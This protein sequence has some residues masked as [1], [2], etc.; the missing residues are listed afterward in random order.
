MPEAIR[1]S[2]HPSRRALLGAAAAGVALAGAWLSRPAGAHPEEESAPPAP[3]R[4]DRRLKLLVL[5]GTR[6]LGPAIV[7]H[8]LARG[9]EVT[10]FNRGKSNPQLYPGLEKLRGDRG[11]PPTPRSPAGTPADL[12]ALEGRSFDAVIDTSGYWPEQM[13]SVVGLLKDHVK[14][15]VF[16]S[17]ISVYPGFGT[18]NT[19]ITEA[20]PTG[21]KAR[22]AYEQWEYGPF[23]ALAE[24][25][26]E[27]L[28]PGR[29]TNIRPGLIVGPGDASDRFTWWPVRVHRGGEVLAPGN[30]EGHCQFIDVRDLGAWSVTCAEQGTV[31]VYNATGFPG[32][33]SFGEF[34]AGCKCAIRTDCSFTWASE[35]FLEKHKVAPFQDMP[36]WIPDAALPWVNVEAAIAQGLTFR[37]IS[38]TIQDTL[39]WALAE[40]KGG[41]LNPR[42]GLAAEREQNLLAAW[43]TLTAQGAAT[44][45][46]GNEGA[47]APREE[48]AAD[49]PAGAGK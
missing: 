3:D 24:A 23:K 48:S 7:D 1:E 44:K 31:G 46:G 49:E 14:Q 8:A 16:I 29:V 19:E 26:A 21:V 35:A 43:R 25:A 39:A 40:P 27:K 20:T 47:P 6:F 45:P 15:Y 33:L 28:M 12:K 5:G 18:S 22:S 2:A 4:A 32:H 41:K 11:S 38:D 9:H 13:E 17:T 34:L 10:L 37:P 42:L 30:P 36:L